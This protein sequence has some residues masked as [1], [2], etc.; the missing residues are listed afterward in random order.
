MSV[1]IYNVGS[2]MFQG[3]VSIA[4]ML[5]DESVFRDHVLSSGKRSTIQ[6]Y[7]DCRGVDRL[8]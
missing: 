6:H 2:V 4:Y 8:S 7:D 3:D 5:L 1:A